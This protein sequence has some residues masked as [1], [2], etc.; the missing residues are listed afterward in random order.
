MVL[1]GEPD[2]TLPQ[3]ATT[4]WGMIDG[5]CWRDADGRFRMNESLGVKKMAELGTLD[6]SDYPVEKHT[7][8]HHIFKGNGA[9]HLKRGAEVEFARGCPYSCTFCKRERGQAYK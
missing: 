1:R 7:H 2:Q 6:Y 8:L 3:L 9:D 4:P 5:C